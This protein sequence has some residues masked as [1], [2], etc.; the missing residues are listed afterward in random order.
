[1]HNILAHIVIRIA[2]VA[3]CDANAAVK[4]RLLLQPV[5]ENF[6]VVLQ[7]F[8]NLAVRLETNGRTG[9]MSARRRTHRRN[10]L[11]ACKFHCVFVFPVVDGCL[12]PFGQRVD[13]RGTDAVQAA[14][15]LI[16]VAAEFTARMQYGQ[17]DFQ[18]RNAHLRMDADRNAASVVAHR[19]D[20]VRLKRD[21]DVGAVARERLVD[22]V[23]DN[24]VHQM[25]QTARGGRAD[26][27]ARPLSDSLQTFQHLNL[28]FVVRFADGQ[29]QNFFAHAHNICSISPADWWER[30]SGRTGR[31][32]PAA[33]CKITWKERIPH[34]TGF[35]IK[36]PVVPAESA[37]CA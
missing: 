9:L 19:D 17:N 29:I 11:A 22:G 2:L 37:R 23:V 20:A 14:G 5:G 18:C 25:V 32:S 10:G 1:M 3:Q 12:E 15:D 27:H 34:G 35:R 16:A 24:F 30:G 36:S 4:E 26:V 7:C 33:A 21:L 13:D 28:I 6:I 8:K 31:R